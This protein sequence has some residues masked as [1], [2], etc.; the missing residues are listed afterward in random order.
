[1]DKH[2]PGVQDL[3]RRAQA[4]D[5]EAWESL[6]ALVQAFLQG[7]V[8]RCLKQDWQVESARDLV[9]ETWLR[10]V[11][12]IGQ[13]RGGGDDY[14]TGAMFRA[15]LAKIVRNLGNNRAAK[16]RP[17]AIGGDGVGAATP[18]APFFDLIADD[19]SPSQRMRDQE[20][21][22]KVQAVLENLPALEREIVRLYFWKQLSYVEIG[23]CL[24]RDE[25]TIR[26]H[27]HQALEHL[28]L[29]MKGLQ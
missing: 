23:R 18:A 2:W 14:Q 8:A 1:M 3:V 24:G 6:F 26:Y 4:G 10:V 27:F 17:V 7:A 25:S 11:K 28:R 15:W 19:P 13:F 16:A 5:S 9:Q 21:I 12:C 29:P 20:T 22:E